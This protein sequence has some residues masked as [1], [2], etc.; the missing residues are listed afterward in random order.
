MLAETLAPR[1]S[2]HPENLDR[3]AAYVEARFR[4]TGAKVTTQPYTVEGRIYRNVIAH[5]GPE[6]G[7]LIVVGAHY[8]TY[9]ATPGADDNGSGVAGLLELAGLLAMES[10]HH[11]ID[12]VAYTLEEPP[13]FRTEHMGSAHHAKG[14][15]DAGRRVKAMVALEMIGTFSDAPQ[16]Q[17]YPIGL[18]KLFYPSQGNF[19]AVVGNLG[20]FGLTRLVKG[21]MRSATPLPVRSMNAPKTLPGIDFSDHR[22]Y[23]KE[24]FPAVMVTDTAF[25]RNHAY[26]EAGDTP[27]RLDYRRMALVVKGVREVVAALGRG[28]D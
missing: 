27:G 14:L 19:I 12:L 7:P 24:G 10:Q 1:D 8:D 15:K 3:V 6:E 9:G 16:S 5:F 2:G 21:A 13:F 20:G 23:W 11:P 4:E 18:L 26:H 22:N 17:G 25:N 28:D